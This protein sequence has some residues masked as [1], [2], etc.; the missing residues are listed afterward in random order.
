MHYGHFCV[1]GWND[2]TVGMSC[3]WLVQFNP[4]QSIWSAQSLADPEEPDR[5]V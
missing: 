2:S 4:W 5:T 1:L 3:T